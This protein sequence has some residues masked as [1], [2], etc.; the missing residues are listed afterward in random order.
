MFVEQVEPSPPVLSRL[1]QEAIGGSVRASND[2]LSNHLGFS[3]SED[4]GI[5][6]GLA[7]SL[8]VSWPLNIVLTE[9]LMKGYQKVFRLML[10][11]EKTYLIIQKTF[12]FLRKQSESCYVNPRLL[13]LNR[14]IINSSRVFQVLPRL[15]LNSKATHM[16]AILPWKICNPL[17][18]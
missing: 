16:I 5:G 8:T 12:L 14:R 17:Q 11:L 1:L 18:N 9:D 2:P 7:L 15:K 10:Q 3:L 13:T 4:D 6:L